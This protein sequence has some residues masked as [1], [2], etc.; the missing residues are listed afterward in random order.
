MCK[1][2]RHPDLGPDE[3]LRFRLDPGVM[4]RLAEAERILGP[5]FGEPG[6]EYS[7]AL[8]PD[9]FLAPDGKLVEDEFVEV[10]R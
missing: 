4:E 3:P 5:I 6:H 1:P 2:Y 7:R 9:V 10:G 8:A